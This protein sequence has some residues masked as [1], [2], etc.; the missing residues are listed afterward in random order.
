MLVACPVLILLQCS[1]FIC[2]SSKRDGVHAVED[3]DRAGGG[4]AVVGPWS[5]LPPPGGRPALAPPLPLADSPGPQLQRTAGCRRRTLATSN[6]TQLSN[7]TS[8]QTF[9]LERQFLLNKH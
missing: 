6:M 8:V 9:P 3:N 7:L 4:G 1:V 5:S 2:W